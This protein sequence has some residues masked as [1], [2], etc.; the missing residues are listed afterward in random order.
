M[1]ELYSK[2]KD[3]KT[4]LPFGN[5]FPNHPKSKILECAQKF[6]ISDTSEI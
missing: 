5:K 3:N 2:T 4:N 1:K 6:S